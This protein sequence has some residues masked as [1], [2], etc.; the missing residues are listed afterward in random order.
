MLW[1]WRGFMNY[2]AENVNPYFAKRLQLLN[3]H[4]VFSQGAR[5]ELYDEAGHK[6]LDFI[7]SFGALPFGFN[8]PEIWQAIYDVQASGEP[9]FTQP[10]FLGAAGELA[11]RLIQI[12]PTGLQYVTFS[13]SG[14]EA[15]E[16]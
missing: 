15:V 9:S 2:F 6:Y 16:A 8:P 14:A 5:C 11:Q 7:A 4:N 1:V 13:N 10:A 3:M 12:A